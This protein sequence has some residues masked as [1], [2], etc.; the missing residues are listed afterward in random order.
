MLHRHRLECFYKKRTIKLL[1]KIVLFIQNKR[2]T[3][4]IQKEK[5][6]SPPGRGGG[7]HPGG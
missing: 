1:T 2:S 7:A 4:Y 3:T 6:V 5:E